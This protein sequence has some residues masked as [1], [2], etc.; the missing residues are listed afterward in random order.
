MCTAI[1]WSG[2]SHYFGRNL[3]LERVYAET[4]TVTPRHYPFRL[5]N[6]ATDTDHAA[7]IGV[8]TVM[9]GIPL[10]YDAVNEHGLGMAGLN[11]V[12]NAHYFE[13]RPDKINLAPHELIP[14]MLSRCR[15]ARE[16]A[17]ALRDINV[18]EHRFRPDL[19]SAPL[20]W[21]IADCDESLVVE[22]MA[23]GLHVYQNPVGVLTNNPPFDFHL[24]HL[25]LYLNVTATEP[26]N[27]FSD[28]LPLAPFSRGMGGLG[29]PGD[30]SSTSRFVRAAFTRAN[31]RKPTDRMVSVSQFFHILGSVEQVE[32]CVA[33]GD[34]WE[35]TQYASCC[36]TKRGIYYFRTYDDPRITAVR[37]RRE[38]LDGE[39]LVSYPLWNEASVRFLN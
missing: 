11:F 37:M 7:M 34:R 13:A 6:G 27:R 1:S 21:M 35:R 31:A 12:G 2:E 22:S 30:V 25:A 38:N 26:V 17:D 20:H 18:W 16:A 9:E 19:P 28:K 14:W 39:Q 10:Y 15:S 36:D 3:D 8:A 5:A 33:V 32:G 23:D 29:L 24:Q 4:V